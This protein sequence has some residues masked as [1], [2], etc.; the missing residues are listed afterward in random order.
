MEELQ[1]NHLKEGGKPIASY[2]YTSAERTLPKPAQ[3]P[4]QSHQL[5]IRL[6]ALVTSR[7]LV[8]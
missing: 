5:R 7:A 8:Q 2:P 1:P 3:Q 6:L 4:E